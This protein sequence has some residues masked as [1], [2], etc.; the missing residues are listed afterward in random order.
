MDRMFAVKT[1]KRVR[2][3]VSGIVQ[4]VGFRPFIYRLAKRD[5][6]SG[7]IRNTSSG[8]CIEIQSDESSKLDRFFLDLQHNAPP[9][10][11]I[12]SVYIEEIPPSSEREFVI[13]SSD[14]EGTAETL[15]AP[16]IAM[17]EA[18]RKELLSPSDRRHGYA[19]LN[20]TDCG[21][22]YT[23]IER[24]PYDRRYTSMKD[25]TMCP[26]CE[27]EYHDPMDRRFHA[28]PN[29]CPVCGP[30]LQILDRNGNAVSCDDPV[31]YAVESLNSS[32]VV[33]V[34]GIGG[35]HL[36][37]DAFDDKA[38]SALRMRKRRE[39]KPFAVMARTIETVEKFCH[40]NASEREA[41]CSPQ[42]PVVLL[43]KKAGNG[44]SEGIAPRNDRLG[45]MLPYAPLH[46]LLMNQ[47]PEM[48]V[49]TSANSSDEPIAIENSEAVSRLQEI[50]DCYLVHDRPVYLRCDDSV[51]VHLAGKLRQIRRSRGYVPEPVPLLSGGASVFSTGA[52]IKNTVCLLKGN[53]AIVSQHIGDLRNYES[54][55]HFQM[56]ADHLQQIFQASPELIVSDMHPA[57]L[58]SLWALEQKDIPSL[59]VQ[60]HHAHLA[61][62]LAE[63]L[64]DAPAIGVILDGTGYGIDGTSWGGEV[65]IGDAAEAY[66]FAFFDPVPLPGG[67]AAVFH[68]WRAAAGYLFH[69]FDTIPELAFMR[70]NDMSG[71]MQLLEKDVNSPVT[72]SCGRLFDAVAVL[73][74][75]CSDVSYEG[76]AAIELMLAA[77]G[78]EGE[79]FSWEISASGNDRWR[80]DLS[81]MIRD[82][83][84]AVQSGVP[85][86]V[87]SS[88]FHVTIVDLLY[89]IVRKAVSFSGIRNVVLSG[90]VF[91]NALLFERLTEKLERHGLTVLT[92]SLVPCND[93]GISLGQA[94][95]GREY[96]K[97][98]YKGVL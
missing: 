14:D 48:L 74:G 60:H 2:C 13:M 64:S 51:T 8:V 17:C 81:P 18:C 43:K 24:I 82:I 20:C 12:T 83:V 32:G 55:R 53:S 45:V 37:V 62:C 93:G 78:F 71:V 25:F 22:R 69:S 68:P 92:H 46:V 31:G 34:K 5:R 3:L 10:A 91:Q 29:A 38:V 35:F 94:V 75:L 98:R 21:P 52:E 84:T 49:M 73:T 23:I 56:V 9:L 79:P 70:D 30:S 41:L 7:Y 67:D 57:Y 54:Y 76:Q 44:L 11:K 42:A 96:L 50:A 59:A 40:I 90:G 6:L 27:R 47:G 65:L 4:G 61:S 66:R 89:T 85:V 86:A 15:V 19:F 63:N 87:I 80:L 1:E 33:A 58:S 95:I 97:G 16:D 77:G 39:E 28:Q 26:D 72:S 36:S 88:R